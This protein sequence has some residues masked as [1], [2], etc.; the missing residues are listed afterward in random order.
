MPIRSQAPAAYVCCSGDRPAAWEGSAMY[1]GVGL[2]TLLII[3]IL[4]IILL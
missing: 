3:I 4:L 1:I 2:G